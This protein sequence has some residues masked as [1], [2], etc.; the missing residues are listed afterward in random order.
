M[1]PVLLLF[2]G[3]PGVGK[4]TLAR[5]DLHCLAPQ[6]LPWPASTASAA[7]LLSK[8]EPILLYKTDASL[9]TV[10]V[11]GCLPAAAV[12]TDRQRRCSGL[13]TAPASRSAADL[14]CQP[15]IV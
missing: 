6:E 14:R 15:A 13:L 12:A 2:K 7:W 11:Q 10:A 5:Y 8:P 9:L 4:S 3:H 1:K